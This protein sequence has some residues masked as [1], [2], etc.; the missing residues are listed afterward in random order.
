MDEVKLIPSQGCRIALMRGRGGGGGMMKGRLQ[1]DM[2]HDGLSA[3]SV[4]QIHFPFQLHGHTSP[5]PTLL[6]SPGARWTTVG[7]LQ[8]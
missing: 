3:A 6:G 8:I 2:S 7:L 5:L 1:L 4:Q